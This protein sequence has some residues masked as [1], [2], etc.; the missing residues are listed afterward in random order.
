M[1]DEQKRLVQEMLDIH[2]DKIKVDAA[3]S[4]VGIAFIWEN[5][6]VDYRIL[7]K[8]RLNKHIEMLQKAREVME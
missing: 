8:E 3:P 6:I 7:D 2:G 5:E 1:S 4:F